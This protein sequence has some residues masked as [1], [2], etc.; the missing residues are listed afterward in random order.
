MFL[1]CSKSSDATALMACRVSDGHQF[2]LGVWQRPH[3]DLSR[4]WLV[5]RSLVDAQVRAAFDRWDVRWFGVDPSPAKDDETEALYWATLI[6]DWHRDFRDSVALWATPGATGNAVLFDMRLSHRG[7]RE[8]LQSFTDQAQRTAA[9]ID[10]EG[11]LTHDGHPV[12]RLHVHQARRRPNQWGMSLSKQTRDSS[13]L[14]DLA[15]AMVGSRLGRRLVLNRPKSET[16]KKSGKV[17]GG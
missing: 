15:V 11:T 4:G 13:K 1:D 12:L 17:W 3:G 8:R 6:D 9:E 10:E 16:G 14:V 5:D 7:G 2:T